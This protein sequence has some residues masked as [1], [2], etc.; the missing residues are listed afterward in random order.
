MDKQINS[1]KA[2]QAYNAEIG[3]LANQ[4]VLLKAQEL[5]YQEEIENWSSQVQHMSQENNDLQIQVSDLQRQIH[6]LTI[7][8]EGEVAYE[9]EQIHGQ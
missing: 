1:E 6:E 8:R 2:F 7:A 3:S 9:N 4:I 5:Q